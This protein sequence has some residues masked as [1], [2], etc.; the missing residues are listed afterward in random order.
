MGSGV[1]RNISGE[2]DK[3]KLA[4]N[5]FLSDG[6]ILLPRRLRYALVHYIIYVMLALNRIY[7]PDT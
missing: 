4:K 2:Y 3:L 6:Y 7:E 1:F 5:I